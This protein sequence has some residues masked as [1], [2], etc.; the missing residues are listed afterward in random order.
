MI[1][2]FLL[3]FRSRKALH[4]LLIDYEAM[5]HKTQQLAE[6]A[7][8][9][10]EDLRKELNKHERMRRDLNDFLIRRHNERQRMLLEADFP[11]MKEA[12]E[13]EESKS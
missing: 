6:T 1:R 4:E 8:S 7:L 9:E 3:W 11:G 2:R 13:R 5:P 12:R 10:L